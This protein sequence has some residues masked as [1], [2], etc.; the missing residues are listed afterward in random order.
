[1]WYVKFLLLCWW[2]EQL[3]TDDSDPNDNNDD[4]I[5]ETKQNY[6][7][8]DIY[9]KWDYKLIVDFCFES[10]EFEQIS[11][12]HTILFETEISM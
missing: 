4:D 1:M 12:L 2:L 6:V 9:T 5:P 7:S 8:F 3:S 10:L 11:L